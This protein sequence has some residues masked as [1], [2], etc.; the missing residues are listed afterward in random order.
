MTAANR[1]PE[2]NQTETVTYKSGSSLG[3][4]LQLELTK[5]GRQIVS[6]KLSGVGGVEL[7]RRL[8]DWRKILIGNLDA[9]DLPKGRSRSVMLLRELILRAQGQWKFPYPE[10][11]LCH[12]RAVKTAVVDDAIL[13]GCHDALQVAR[14]TSA[15]TSC[16][17]CKTDSEAVIRYRLS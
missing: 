11:E 6:A 15:G 13:N 3:D 5:S 17:A 4:Q 1:N 2:T 8:A 16:G 14:E 12:C 10:D 7:L 9:V